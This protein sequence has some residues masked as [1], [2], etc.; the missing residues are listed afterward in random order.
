MSSF[1]CRTCT[2]LSATDR[3]ETLALLQQVMGVLRTRPQTWQDC[4]VWALGH[5]Q[6][7]FHDKVLEGGT[8]FSSGS[9]KCPHPLQFDPNHVSSVSRPEYPEGIRH[10]CILHAKREPCLCKFKCLSL[11][12][13]GIQT[14]PQK[15]NASHPVYP[16]SCSL[17]GCRTCISSTYWQL[18]TCMHGCMGCLAHK[19][20]L[21]SG[22]C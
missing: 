4:V 16:R 7:C 10:L 11:R 5:W 2:S 6:L 12:E 17:P 13:A 8:Q 1:L 18:P 14:D 21:H 20:S 3:T 19:V 9:N 22:N 15:G